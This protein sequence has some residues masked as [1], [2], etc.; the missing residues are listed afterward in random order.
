MWA[1]NFVGH[2]LV[3]GPKSV[4]AH[5]LTRINRLV[6]LGDPDPLR[7][8]RDFWRWASRTRSVAPWPP[9]SS[10][11][12]SV[13]PPAARAAGAPCRAVG[14]AGRRA[15]RPARRAA[16]ADRAAPRARDDAVGG[17]HRARAAGR[18]RQLAPAPRPRRAGPRGGPPRMTAL[19]DL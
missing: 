15:A 19:A 10:P 13:A 8:A 16:A 2:P 12:P 5:G 14:R 17:R 4:L 1:N 11:S 3:A 9:P 6:P 7:G 18:H